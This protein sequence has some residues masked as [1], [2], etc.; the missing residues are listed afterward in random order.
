MMRRGV[1]ARTALG[2]AGGFVLGIAAIALVSD[3][4]EARIGA[5]L[6]RLDAVLA[7]LADRLF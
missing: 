7:D 3:E 5:H 6:A 1:I 4:T 2:L